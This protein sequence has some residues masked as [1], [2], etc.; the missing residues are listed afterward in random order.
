PAVWL[1]PAAPPAATILGEF[2]GVLSEG[3]FTA[4]HLV[5]P[6]AGKTL[7][8]LLTAIREDRAYVNVHTL[9]FPAGEIRGGLK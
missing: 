8:D 4:A 3:V 7:A 1:Y 9:Q 6:L 2:T 5:G